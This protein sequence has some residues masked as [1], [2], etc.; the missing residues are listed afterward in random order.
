M[1]IEE[2]RALQHE[3]HKRKSPFHRYSKVR[4]GKRKDLDNKFFRSA[5]EANIARYFTYLQKIGTVVEWQYEPKRFRFPI[6][7]GIN[8]YIPDFSVVWAH[9][10]NKVI[11]YEVK[12]YMDKPSQVK[13]KRMEQYFPDIEIQVID[14]Q[15]YSVINNQFSFLPHWE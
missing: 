1:T 2:Y 5:W 14:K 4:Q 6:E 9:E 13:L 8:F 12:G 3:E 15:R 10:P 7:R 11:Y